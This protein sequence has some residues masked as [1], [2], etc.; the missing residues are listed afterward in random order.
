MVDSGQFIRPP[1]TPNVQEY[2]EEIYQPLDDMRTGNITPEE[3]I[4]TATTGVRRTF[5]Q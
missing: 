3:A 4:E 2:T 1:A 5:D